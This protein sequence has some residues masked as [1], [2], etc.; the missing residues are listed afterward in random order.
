MEDDEYMGYRIPKGA[1]IFLNVYTIHNDPAQFPNPEKF[2]PDRYKDES[3]SLF[4]TATSPEKRGTFVFGAGRR[5][6][7]VSSTK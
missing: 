3:E 5:S 2:D 7:P 4:G 6:C 1:G